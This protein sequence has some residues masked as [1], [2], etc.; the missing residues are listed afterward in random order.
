[1]VSYCRGLS[2]SI[3]PSSASDRA[4]KSPLSRIYCPCAPLR[5]SAAA[6]VAP[7]INKSDDRSP[8]GQ[9]TCDPGQLCEAA[10]LLRGGG[11]MSARRGAARRSLLIHIPLT[12]SAQSG[13]WCCRQRACSDRIGVSVAIC[14]TA[15]MMS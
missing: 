7:T 14:N 12:L 15:C 8:S 6:H 4:E 2:P 13:V 9:T 1:M 3:P 11:S 5:R 10:P